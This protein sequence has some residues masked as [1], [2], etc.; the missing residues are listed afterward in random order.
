[1]NSM[2]GKGCVINNPLLLSSCILID[3]NCKIHLM[4]F[5]HCI[6]CFVND[7]LAGYGSKR[8]SPTDVI[9]IALGAL[10]EE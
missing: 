2:D 6:S 1:M 5:T 7:V 9:R 8:S 3:D 4:I 10:A